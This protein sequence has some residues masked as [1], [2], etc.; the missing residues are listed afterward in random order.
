M[1]EDIDFDEYTE[2]WL[3]GNMDW[4][5]VPGLDWEGEEICRSCYNN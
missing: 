3:C 2:C 5:I 1:T 4:C